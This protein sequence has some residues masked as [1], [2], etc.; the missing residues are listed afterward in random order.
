M[1][2]IHSLRVDCKLAMEETKDC[3]IV[4]PPQLRR[5]NCT[6][7]RHNREKVLTRSKSIMSNEFNIMLQCYNLNKL[8]V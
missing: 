8:E 1:K 7:I 3:P 5:R 6:F 4:R 2:N